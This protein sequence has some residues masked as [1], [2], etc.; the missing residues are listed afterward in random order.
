MPRKQALGT[1]AVRALLQLLPHLCHGHFA[2]TAAFQALD[3][4]EDSPR[5][6]AERGAERAV[7]V[8]GVLA[9]PVVGCGA[10]GKALLLHS[11]GLS[12]GQFTVYCSTG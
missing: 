1:R 10:D 7:I 9:E 11:C 4:L 2:A 5:C 12:T 6:G 3:G 8:A